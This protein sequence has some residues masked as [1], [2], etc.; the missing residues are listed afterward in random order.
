MSLEQN[1]ATV[2]KFV[3]AVN[4]QDI[5]LL[6]EIATPAIAKEW[7]EA[8]VSIYT[9]MQGHTI[10]LTNMVAE[11]DQVAVKMATSGY[12]TGELFGLPATGKWWTNRVFTFFRF[13]DG[14]I[15]EV[16]ALPDAENHIKQLGATIT[17]LA[18]LS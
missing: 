18:Q 12:H 17:P 15:A 7:T 5:G 10:E 9:T 16:D 11:A 13:E 8:M 6:S 2:Q 14:K 1:K 3:D 4:R